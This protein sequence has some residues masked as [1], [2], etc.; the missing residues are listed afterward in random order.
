M[1]QFGVGGAWVLGLLPP[2][3]RR[4]S[5]RRTWPAV[6]CCRPARPGRARSARRYALASKRLMRA[7][8]AYADKMMVGISVSRLGQALVGAGESTALPAS[9]SGP[10]W[11]ATGKAGWR[12][13]A[14]CAWRGRGRSSPRA[15]AW[16]PS[17]PRRA[18]LSISAAVRNPWRRVTASSA[19]P[20]PAG[21]CGLGR[22]Q[23]L[24]GRPVY[25][26]GAL[27]GPVV[28]LVGKGGAA[29]EM[30]IASGQAGDFKGH[31]V[32]DGGAHGVVLHAGHQ[33]PVCSG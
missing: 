25:H 33:R 2:G 17:T 20:R 5:V 29:S 13:C 8:W 7:R 4:F 26:V 21:A 11:G 6:R 3:R 22:P 14:G 10:L 31:V 1:F 24:G 9:V 18:R 32:V 16:R 12:R 19:T 28:I 27:R 15:C 30:H 23:H